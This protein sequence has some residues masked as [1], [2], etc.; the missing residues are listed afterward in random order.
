ME[1]GHPF[2]PL[3]GCVCRVSNHECTSP[4]LQC[5]LPLRPSQECTWQLGRISRCVCV[6]GSIC[7]HI[8]YV[9]GV[10]LIAYRRAYKA[11]EQGTVSLWERPT[12]SLI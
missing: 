11:P 4:V 1:G 6:G 3:S 8:M 5:Y 2:S 10:Y 9:F 7:I 12:N